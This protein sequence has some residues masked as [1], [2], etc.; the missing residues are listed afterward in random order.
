MGEEEHGG[1]DRVW[2]GEVTTKLDNIRE[3]IKDLKSSFAAHLMMCDRSRMNYMERVSRLEEASNTR[4]KLTMLFLSIL[5]LAVALGL[6][7]VI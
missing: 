4:H 1:N 3:D 6:F 2:K 5:S 7:K